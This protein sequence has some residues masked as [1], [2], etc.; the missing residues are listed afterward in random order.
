[1]AVGYCHYTPYP[2]IG[3]MADDMPD[4][5]SANAT[6]HFY[7]L[8]HGKPNPLKKD[9]LNG[10]LVLFAHALRKID[11]LEVK[12][13]THSIEEVANIM[14]QPNMLD[15]IHKQ[16]FAKFQRNSILIQQKEYIIVI[17]LEATIQQATVR[18]LVVYT[19]QPLFI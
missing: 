12:P 7:L 8:L 19:T 10:E 16:L 6:K 2:L 18:I 15:K 5:E 13:G 17:E 14:H 9:T 4:P 1:M 11:L 3:L